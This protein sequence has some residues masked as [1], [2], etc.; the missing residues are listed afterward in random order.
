MPTTLVT[1]DPE[2]VRSG[3]MMVLCCGPLLLPALPYLG[4]AIP[5]LPERAVTTY[6]GRAGSSVEQP[7]PLAC[8]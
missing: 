4:P 8:A 3:L 2:G 6:S 5:D 1:W 7:C